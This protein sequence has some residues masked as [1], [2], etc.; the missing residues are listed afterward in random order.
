LCKKTTNAKDLT[1]ECFQ[2]TVLD[3]V[4]NSSWVQY[5][6]GRGRFEIDAVRT[7]EGTWPRGSQ[8]TRVPI[9]AE[10][11]IFDPV[12]HERNCSTYQFALPSLHGQPVEAPTVLGG[13]H[14]EFGGDLVIVDKLRIPDDLP[15]GEYVLSW[16]IDCEQSP[17]IWNTCA[18]IAIVDTDASIPKNSE[19]AVK[20]G[21]RCGDALHGC[22]LEMDGNTSRC[23]LW[24]SNS[25]CTLSKIHCELPSSG[26]SSDAKRKWSGGFVTNVEDGDIR[27]NGT[28][29]PEIN[30]N[31]SNKIRCEDSTTKHACGVGCHQVL[32]GAPFPMP[33][34]CQMYHEP[35]GCTESKAACESDACK[36]GWWIDVSK[37]QVEN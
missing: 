3:F 24:A 25:Q 10:N 22:C 14:L 37:T 19:L 7:R 2:Q 27:C 29:I 9:P 1:E 32:A 34:Q 35:G 13:F 21:P 11:C 12:S 33:L 5:L 16:R 8:W 30:T 20:P 36:K 4:G 23:A 28:W 31:T 15:T 17:Q 26:N 6:D 18:S